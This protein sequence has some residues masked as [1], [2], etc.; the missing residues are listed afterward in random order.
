MQQPSVINDRKKNIAI[1]FGGKSHEHQVSLESS[2]NIFNNLNRNKYNITLI[3]VDKNGRWILEYS[4][5][6][7][8]KISNPNNWSFSNPCYL[9]MVPGNKKIQF[10]KINNGSPIPKIDIIFSV[11]HGSYG[12]DGC[13]QGLLES[14]NI[15]Y[16]GSNVLG[17]ALCMDKDI[18]KRLLRSARIPVTPSITL[19]KDKKSN[20]TYSYIISKLGLPLFVKPT[21]QGSSIGVSKISNQYDFNQALNL[22]YSYSKK[23][24][25]EKAIKGREI[26]IGILGIPQKLFHSVCGEISILNDLPNNSHYTYELKYSSNERVKLI[27][28][29][30]NLSSDLNVKLCS[31]A[32]RAFLLLNCNVMARIDFFLT[33]DNK[34]FLN[35]INTIPG[36]TS[37][38]TY[39]KLWEKSGMNYSELLD[40]LIHL[41]SYED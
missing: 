29:A 34:I 14:L 23:I 3:R 20:P 7:L 15:P 30:N 36:F 19:W 27:I 21:N 28:P 16:V 9:A 11:L 1:V 12:E 24:L 32:R 22:A 8:K 37:L 38:S 10:I 39:P 2:R 18:T 6:Y 26:E 4:S 5:L 25:I 40:R 41:S 31:I 35:E 17:S 13:I 33:E